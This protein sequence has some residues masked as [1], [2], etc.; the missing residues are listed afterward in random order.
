MLRDLLASIFPISATASDEEQHRHFTCLLVGAF[1]R[2]QANA[3]AK[4]CRLCL[5]RGWP[6][7]YIPTP[8]AVFGAHLKV[9]WPLEGSGLRWIRAITSHLHTPLPFCL[10]AALSESASR[11]VLI[12][13]PCFPSSLSLFPCVL[14]S[15]LTPFTQAAL[16][17]LVSSTAG[18]RLRCR[19]FLTAFL[20]CLHCASAMQRDE[21]LYCLDWSL[22]FVDDKLPVNNSKKNNDRD[23]HTAYMQQMIERNNMALAVRVYELQSVIADT[24]IADLRNRFSNAAIVGSMDRTHRC[25][26]SGGA[27]PGGQSSSSEQTERD[28]NEAETVQQRNSTTPAA[29]LI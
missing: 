15:R 3:A 24:N 14:H 18:L 19:T 22:C 4:F 11:N 26:H 20:T 1:T 21:L 27:A 9:L 2:R 7:L 8:S 23:G 12:Y 16:Q 28:D 29:S 6:R 25:A 10:W 5:G 13:L 17:H